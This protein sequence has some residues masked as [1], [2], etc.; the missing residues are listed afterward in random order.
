MALKPPAHCPRRNIHQR[1]QSYPDP[2]RDLFGDWR[3]EI[4][5]RSVDGKELRIYTTTVPTKHRITP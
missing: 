3:E 1:N 4:I 2:Q 5:W